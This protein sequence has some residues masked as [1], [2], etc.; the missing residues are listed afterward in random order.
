MISFNGFDCCFYIFLFCL[1]HAI[2]TGGAV[3]VGTIIARFISARW[4]TFIGAL[5][6]LGFAVASIFTGAVVTVMNK[7][8]V[9]IS[10]DSFE[11]F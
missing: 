1:G 5:V 3:L 10:V 4:I 8:Q 2:C 7:P 11:F 6:F 9:Q